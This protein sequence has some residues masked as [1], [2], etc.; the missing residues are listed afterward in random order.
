[1]AIHLGG[2]SRNSLAATRVVLDKA[3][4]GLSGDAASALSNDLFA[5]VNALGQNVALRRAITDPA[6]SAEDKG[7]LLKQLFGSKISDK[8]FEIANTAI[9][10]RWS[11]PSDLLISMEQIAIQAEA[12][13]ANA[14]GELDKLEEEVFTFTRVLAS[15]QDLR[16]ALNGN[17][18]AINEKRALVNDVLK[19]ATSSARSLIGQIV[20]GLWGR[21]IENAL[22]DIAHATAEHRHLVVAHVSSAI[23]LTVDQRNKLADALTKQ[24]GQKVRVNVET[25]PKVI[26]GVSI[27]FRDELIDGTVISRMAEASQAL[28]G[29]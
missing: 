24:I 7:G 25:N 11:S 18:D 27:R 23:D 8:A 28:A 6:R 12:G 15:N 3:L 16:N 20:N 10:N 4:S 2:S 22:S 1:M 14:R 9:A 13:A 19:G 29:K 5:V 21:N 26:G 17:P